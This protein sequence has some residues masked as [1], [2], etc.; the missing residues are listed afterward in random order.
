M[1]YY[2]TRAFIRVVLW[3]YFRV[4][5]S[6]REN[7]AVKGAVILAPVHRSNLDA[8]LLSALTRRRIRAV[9]KESLFRVNPLAWFISALGAFPVRRG[10]ADRESL[11]AA[12][13]LLDRKEMLLVF[14]EGGR[15]H[16]DHIGDLFHGTAYLAARSGASVIPVGIAGTEEAM[17]QGVRFPRPR[18]VQV[19][20]GATLRPPDFS[21]K[22]SEL[23]SWTS[24][25]SVSL[26]SVQMEAR[27]RL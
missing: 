25:L 16:G 19:V 1:V 23:R 12:R 2:L 6:G 13:F 3:S 26:Q 24:E 18:K 15:Q 8:L 11:R 9:A 27:S 4:E 5:A 10:S 22:R 20:V 7:L 14:P 17:A 21:A